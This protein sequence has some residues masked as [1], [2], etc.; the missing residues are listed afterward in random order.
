LNRGSLSMTQPCAACGAVESNIV[1]IGIR[2]SPEITVRRC[3]ACTL[4][5]LS[6]IPTENELENYYTDVYRAEYEGAV[7][8]ENSYH[9]GI[10]PARERVRRVVGLV[11]SSTKVLE[12]GA[13][14]GTFLESVRPYV[15]SVTGVEPGVA[16]AGWARTQLGINVVS[17]IA[18]LKQGS[19]DLIA[20]F[21]TL[22]HVLD[23]IG[24]LERL[25][26]LLAPGGCLVIEVPNVDDALLTLYKVAKFS[27]FYFQRAHLYYFSPMTLR[28]VL[29]KAGAD[30]EIVGIQRYDLSN[31]IQWMLTGEP[32]GQALYS[33][34]FPASLNQ[35]YA[36]ALIRSGFADTLWATARFNHL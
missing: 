13:S 32:G 2:Y 27:S 18:E 36:E 25:K 19:F 14:A 16:H 30:V 1:Q 7:S 24:F 20:L 21:H 22:E 8:P 33:A 17:S 4:T 35:I 11:N 10:E 28:H 23:P 31:H 34:V 12:V 5:F 26:N 9:K 3:V 15:G 6:P 29:A